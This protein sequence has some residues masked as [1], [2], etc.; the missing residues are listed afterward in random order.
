MVEHLQ[1]CSKIKIIQHNVNRNFSCMHSCLESAIQNKIDFVLMQEPALLDDNRTTISH[2]AYYCI[3]PECSSSKR[4]RVA[5]YTRKN[6]S[7]QYCV[8]RDLTSDSDI[9]I[10]DVSGLNINTFQ[11]INIYNQKDQSNDEELNSSNSNSS[12]S[13][14]FERSMKNI[15][16]SS[17][18]LILGDFNAHHNW[19]NSF[20]SNNIR[21]NELIPWLNQYNFELVNE[22]DVYTFHR[23]KNEGRNMTSSIIDLAFATSSLYSRISEWFIDENNSTGS[24]HELI[25]ISIQTND[26]EL[27]DN[28]LMSGP[29]NVKKANWEL[30]EKELTFEASNFSNSFDNLNS[31]ESLEQAARNLQEIIQLAAEKSISRR[32]F[33]EKSKV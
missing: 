5:I 23:S 6:S 16:L 14:T 1:K 4:P 33:F 29:F 20:I 18:T 27:V 15:Q 32:K 26:I 11:L 25:R 7:Y 21:C 22:P 31:F 8:R 13:Y 28:P 19:W 10:L 17:E 30:F 3:L 2:N 12:N 9:L 24:D